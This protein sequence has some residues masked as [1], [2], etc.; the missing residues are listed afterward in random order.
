ML[1]SAKMNV[2]DPTNVPL[3]KKILV[4]EQFRVLLLKLHKHIA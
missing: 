1:R 2:I 3:K 4:P